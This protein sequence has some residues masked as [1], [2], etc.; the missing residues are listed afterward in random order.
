MLG[1]S[2]NEQSQNKHGDHGPFTSLYHHLTMS[3]GSS[4]NFVLIHNCSVG[5]MWY[6]GVDVTISSQCEIE[7][8]SYKAV[9]VWAQCSKMDYRIWPLYMWFP[10]LE[11]H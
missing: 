4:K 11:P 1:E 8:L 3:F 10:A 7:S 6:E 2:A 9:L 5:H